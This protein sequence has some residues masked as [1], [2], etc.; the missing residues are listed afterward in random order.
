MRACI[1]PTSWSIQ[2]I[3]RFTAGGKD[4]FFG[5]V[6]VE[7]ALLRN[8]EVISEAAKR[9][10]DAYRAAHPAIPWRAL[11]G[12]RH[13]LIHQYEGVDL[14]KVWAIVEGE[15]PGLRQAIAGLLPP[16]DQLER[17]LAGEGEA[18][19]EG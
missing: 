17:E 10:D 2:K 3:E 1:S 11:A 4:H 7:D 12:L 9:L 6:M 19:G 18:P 13:V 5:D 15:L 16:L 8:L 14:E